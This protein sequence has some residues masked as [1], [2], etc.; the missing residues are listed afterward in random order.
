[1][2][3]E[4]VESEQQGGPTGEGTTSVFFSDY[5]I[6]HLSILTSLVVLVHSMTYC[7]WELVCVCVLQQRRRASALI[8]ISVFLHHNGIFLRANGR[9]SSQSKQN[10]GVRMYH[11]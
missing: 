3:D 9:Q 4:R 10:G 8:V 11:R 6:V 5:S 7:T 2:R 1:M